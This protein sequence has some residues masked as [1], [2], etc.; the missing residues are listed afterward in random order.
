MLNQCVSSTTSR[1]EGIIQYYTRTCTCTVYYYILVQYS[2]SHF[3]HP[4]K[5]LNFF[6]HLLQV[7]LDASLHSGQVLADLNLNALEYACNGSITSPGMK[8]PAFMSTLLT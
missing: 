3:P 6:V 7:V 4:L 8:W 5:P 2:L 1:F